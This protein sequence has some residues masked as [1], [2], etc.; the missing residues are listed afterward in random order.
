MQGLEH[1]QDNSLTKF[2]ATKFHYGHV[3]TRDGLSASKG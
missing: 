2:K 3:Y 1:D